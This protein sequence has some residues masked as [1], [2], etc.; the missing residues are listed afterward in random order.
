MRD[1]APAVDR[2]EAESLSHELR[3]ALTSIQG[4]LELVLDGD[5]GQLDAQAREVL[6][7]AHRSSGQLSAIVERLE[8]AMAVPRS[9]RPTSRHDVVLLDEVIAEVTERIRRTSHTRI[10]EVRVEDGV[11]PAP[12]LG[13]H[14]QLVAVFF[15]LIHS[16]TRGPCR[17]RDVRVSLRRVTD[18]LV[19]TVNDD[20][21]SRRWGVAPRPDTEPELPG[22]LGLVVVR[23]VLASYGGTVS[24]TPLRGGRVRVDIRLPSVASAAP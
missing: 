15:H 11:R 2:P 23:S 7:R 1:Q 21:P 3:T 12:V 13:D 14:R 9:A 4:H 19:V 5:L 17:R 22:G 10:P 24:L 8:E 20:A 6:S 18:E 16:A